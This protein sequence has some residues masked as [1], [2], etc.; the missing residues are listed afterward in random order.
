MAV[1]GPFVPAAGDAVARPQVRPPAP[2]RL[3]SAPA[4]CRAS[5]PPGR[6]AS[7]SRRCPGRSSSPSPWAATT[8]SSESG[9]GG[10]IVGALAVVPRPR[11]PPPAPLPCWAGRPS[12]KG[13]HQFTQRRA[14]C[15]GAPFGPPE[16]RALPGLGWAWLGLA[17]LGLACHA[18]GPGHVSLLCRFP[19]PARWP[20]AAVPKPREET[21]LCEA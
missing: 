19:P 2:Q 18:T 8:A 10:P 20:L 5:S 11:S 1:L 14:W 9:C 6:T 17:W 15:P 13:R 12:P 16:S 7:P 21:S 4:P 3:P